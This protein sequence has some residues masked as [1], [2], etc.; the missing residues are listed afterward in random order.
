MPGDIT[1]AV[2]TPTRKTD[3]LF[4]AF[5]ALNN[6]SVKRTGTVRSWKW[7]IGE[8]EEPV[9]KQ[10]VQHPQVKVVKLRPGTTASLR[11]Q[12]IEASAGTHILELDPE[13][14]LRPNAIQSLLAANLDVAY[15]D[16]AILGPNGYE[17]MD[18]GHGWTHRVETVDGLDVP[19]VESFD[20]CPRSLCD[21]PY[22]PSGPKMWRRSAI[23]ELGGY[24][25]DIE[26]GEEIDLICRAYRRGLTVGRVP[27]HVATL[28]KLDRPRDLGGSDEYKRRLHRD[29]KAGVDQYLDDLVVEW[30][31]KN[32]LR[33]GGDELVNADPEGR[34]AGK[35]GMIWLDGVIHKLPRDRFV[36]TVN[37]MY[38]LLAPGGWLRIKTP[39][40]DGRGAFQDPEALS[41]WNQNS[42]LY[43]TDARLSATIANV[44]CRFQAFRVWTAA[45]TEFESYLDIRHARGDLIALKGQRQ[46][47]PVRI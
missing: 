23:V 24:D 15:G 33:I 44:D 35:Y 21:A 32:D 17:R 10:I 42:F 2:V 26:A 19:V 34:Q 20:P 47:G 8:T 37:A 9:P 46:P 11:Q 36:P 41:Y 40:T 39:S 13:D 22:S 3:W 12:V 28:R 31:R 30:C 7:T 25:V 1:V 16:A 45:F 43:F 14:T 6:Q 4:E 38:D 18:E 29:R 5:K 27:E